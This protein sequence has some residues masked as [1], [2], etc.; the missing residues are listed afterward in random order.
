MTYK[1]DVCNSVEFPVSTFPK[2]QTCAY[3]LEWKESPYDA[4]GQLTVDD[5]AVMNVWGIP[6]SKGDL[7]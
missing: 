4:D 1:D 5:L 2:T 6:M 7:L 3:A